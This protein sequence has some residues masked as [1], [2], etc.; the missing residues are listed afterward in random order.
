MRLLFALL[1][2]ASSA[3]AAPPKDTGR[4][5]PRVIAQEPKPASLEVIR[6]IGEKLD[7][8]RLV[9]LVTIG[10]ARWTVYEPFDLQVVVESETSLLF[11]TPTKPGRVSIFANVE[12]DGPDIF[13]PFV[14]QVGE[15]PPVPPT[16]VPPPGP[17]PPG[18]DPP[19][20][21]PPPV[22]PNPDPVIPDGVPDT[23]GLGRVAYKSAVTI[24]SNARA[25]EAAAV[26]AIFQATAD[27]LWKLEDLHEVIYPQLWAEVKTATAANA[28]S[29]ST[30]ESTLRA[31]IKEQM[32]AKKIVTMAD[33]RLSMVEVAKALSFVK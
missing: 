15:V 11:V 17:N 23:Y 9:R 26:A 12:V 31:R 1:L 28:A 29:W 18:P 24:P 2:L 10:P 25:S 30:F 19:G 33:W 22:P 20:P 7:P 21:T 32:A 5:A 8:G 14:I 16:P 4:P 3:L 6:P 27:R 13:Q